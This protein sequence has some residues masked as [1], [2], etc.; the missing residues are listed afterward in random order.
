[1]VFGMFPG[2]STELFYESSANISS[3]G[4]SYV[5]KYEADIHGAGL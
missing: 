1:M 5:E 4:V 2:N 3:P